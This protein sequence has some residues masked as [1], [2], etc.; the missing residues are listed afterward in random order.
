[1]YV[2]GLRSGPVLC[3]SHP[4]SSVVSSAPLPHRTD[5]VPSPR[6]SHSRSLPSAGSPVHACCSP[7]CFWAPRGLVSGRLTPG[8][9]HCHPS[10]ASVPW[11]LPGAAL[12]SG[13]SSAVQAGRHPWAGW[14][15][16]QQG[17]GLP[18]AF[19]EG[20]FIPCRPR[21]RPGASKPM[22]CSHWHLSCVPCTLL[23]A[24][25]PPPALPKPQTRAVPTWGAAGA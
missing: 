14:E 11:A 9:G 10:R 15:S 1:M 7:G 22:P 21:E 25:A 4:V 5:R 6:F 19:Q 8:G 2:W 12:H 18:A 17:T 16:G 24:A 13:T 3:V 20:G 23:G